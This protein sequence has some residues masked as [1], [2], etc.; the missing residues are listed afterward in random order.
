MEPSLTDTLC[1]RCALCCDGSLFAD[2]ELAGRAEATGLEILGIAVE[3]D[4]TDGGLLPLPCGALRGTRC[5]I[6]AHRPQCCRTFECGLLQSVR[7]GA[8]SVDRATQLI[9]ETR[10]RVERVK[11]LMAQLAPRRRRL[12]LRESCAE[13]LAAKP[14]A[15]PEVNRQRA[16]L[17]AAMSEVEA[18][19]DAAFLSGGAGGPRSREA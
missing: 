6:Y 18:L 3:D 7:R 13:T 1:T 5:G 10:E 11:Q 2:V 19:I 15:N 16:E 17:E 4:D 14:S 8:V 9:A 12:S